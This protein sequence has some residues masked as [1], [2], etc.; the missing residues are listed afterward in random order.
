MRAILTGDKKALQDLL[1]NIYTIIRYRL[2]V[3]DSL[4]MHGAVVKYG[5]DAI[6]FCGFSGAG[7]ST[8]ATLWIEHLGAT[9]INLDKP[10][11]FKDKGYCVH[12]TPWSGK[13]HCYVNRQVPLRAIV[14]VEKGTTDKVEL[15]DRGDAFLRLYQNNLVYPLNDTIYN[16]Y[17]EI[18]QD[19]VEEVPVYNLV[20]TKSEKAVICLYEALYGDYSKAREKMETIMRIKD[21]FMLRNIADEWIVVPRGSHALTFS[22]LVMLNESGAFLWKCMQNEVTKSQLVD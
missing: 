3:M 13:E 8:Q 17:T 5:N 18:T 15:L 7:K 4:A 19:V 21:D 12:G 16:M 1:Y 9:P 20:C 2:I 6:M 14:F 11:L 22:G 10:F